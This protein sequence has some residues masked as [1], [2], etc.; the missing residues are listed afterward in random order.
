MTPEFPQKLTMKLH[1]LATRV[2]I[3]ASG[4]AIGSEFLPALRLH[5]ADSK[6]ATA[7]NATPPQQ[8]VHARREVTSQVAPSTHRSSSCYR[9]PDRDTNW[10]RIPVQ[11]DLYAS[12]RTCRIV[13]KSVWSTIT[14]L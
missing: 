9:T 8:Q 14:M 3:D 1:A 6:T 4:R 5:R 11:I 7:D 13:T 10:R 2:M 12:P